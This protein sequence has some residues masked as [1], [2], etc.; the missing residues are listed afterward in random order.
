MLWGRYARM[1][2]LSEDGDIVGTIAKGGPAGREANQAFKALATGDPE[3][4]RVMNALVSYRKGYG[5]KEIA[6][7]GG[8]LAGELHLTG[9]AIV[10]APLI[11][12]KLASMARDFMT[13]RGAG[14]PVTMDTL[15][16]QQ[17]VMAN[18]ANAA[19]AG[20]AGAVAGS[21]QAAG[22]PSPPISY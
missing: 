12:A 6:T 9:S 3:A 8:I 17:R 13:Q 18:P 20:R 22:N 7:Y 10:S 21:Q 11:A 4:Q 14:R 5:M 16:R 1:M 19:T 2:K 15:L